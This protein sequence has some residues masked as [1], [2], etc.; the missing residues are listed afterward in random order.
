MYQDLVQF[1]V[2]TYRDVFGL[3]DGPPLHDPVAVAV[4]LFDEGV[5]DLE[6]DDRGGERFGIFVRPEG[7]HESPD[8]H[9]RNMKQAQLG[10]TVAKH[11]GSGV[12]GIRI[13]RGLNVS[14]FWDMIENCL[15]RAEETLL[16]RQYQ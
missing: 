2:R 15:Q 11:L 7:E 12:D 8:Y 9:N 10:R 14:R 16:A 3:K 1:Y 13:P 4:I 6:Y 5:E